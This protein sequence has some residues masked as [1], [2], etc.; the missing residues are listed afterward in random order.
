MR[1]TH[2]ARG[3]RLSHVSSFVGFVALTVACGGAGSA[4]GFGGTT[5]DGGAATGADGST[6]AEDAGGSNATD[7]GGGGGGGF[8]AA[9]DPTDGTPTRKAC[10]NS[11]GS[12]LNAF[13]GRIDGFLVAIV[14]QGQHSCNGDS[15]HVHLQ[16]EMSGSVY[17]VAVN[18]D[19]LE[20]ELSHPMVDGAWSEGW[21]TNADGLDYPNALGIHSAAFATTNATT[22]IASLAN[23]NHISVFATG[24]GP[25]GIHLVH[26]KGG[27]A[28][29]AIIAD[30]LGAN[31]HFYV[32]RF[33]T[34]S[35]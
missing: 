1:L 7:A 21:H 15:S 22:L 20:A 23:V 18:V 25:T 5:A 6:A 3:V 26:R 35:F 8:D 16:V 32:F 10:T 33:A 19:G 9:S 11:F 27:G 34:D 24:Y 31:P 12:G 2:S 28:D 14:P 4:G 17:D 30:P 13:H 29:G